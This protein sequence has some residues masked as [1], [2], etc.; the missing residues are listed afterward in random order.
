MGIEKTYLNI[1]TVIY[2]KST[3]SIMPNTERQKVFPS[4]ISNKT[5]VSSLKTPD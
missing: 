1:I 3:A 4:K 5:K 2:K